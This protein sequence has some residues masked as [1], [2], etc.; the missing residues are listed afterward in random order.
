MLC[1]Y[2]WP[3]DSYSANRRSERIKKIRENFFFVLQICPAL[4]VGAASVPRFAYKR[5]LSHCTNGIHCGCRI[6]RY[7]ART[8]SPIPELAN[9]LGHPDRKQKKGINKMETT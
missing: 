8:A 4:P 3:C 1:Q 9:N 2:Y 6:A 7:V 5:R